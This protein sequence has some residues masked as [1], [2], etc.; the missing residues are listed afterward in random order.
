ME[1]KQYDETYVNELKEKLDSARTIARIMGRLMPSNIAT[2]DQCIIKWD[3]DQMFEFP[4]G[5]SRPVELEELVSFAIEQHYR[6]VSIVVTEYDDTKT[7]L[8]A[9]IVALHPENGK[10]HINTIS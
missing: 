2:G 3:W 9:F 5:R 1:Q 10:L 4:K 8:H 6:I 7:A